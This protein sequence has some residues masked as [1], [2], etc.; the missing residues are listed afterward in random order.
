MS[1]TYYSWTIPMRD[2]DIPMDLSPLDDLDMLNSEQ[3]LW[4]DSRND[5]LTGAL[6]NVLSVFG[7][8][9]LAFLCR[10]YPPQHK[11]CE[12]SQQ[13]PWEGWSEFW[14]GSKLGFE[15]IEQA[16]ADIDSWLSKSQSEPESFV[17]LLGQFPVCEIEDALHDTTDALTN[18]SPEKRGE[19]DDVYYFFSFL[20]CLRSLLVKAQSQQL[21][22][23][24]VRCIYIREV[25]SLKPIPP[26]S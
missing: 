17:E 6:G 1:T 12:G 26:V 9:A 16:I 10:E 14:L 24:H 25:I 7:T 22:I 2:I 23:L 8:R 15:Q 11:I 4:S 18:K 3:A 5:W 20:K 13:N 21:S 19:G